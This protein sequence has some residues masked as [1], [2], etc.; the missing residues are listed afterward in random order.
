VLDEDFF[1]YKEDVDLAWRLQRLGWTAWYV[2][3][4]RAWHGRTSGGPR[5]VTML[6]IARANRRVPGWIGAISWRNQRLTQLKNDRFADYVR[7]LPW[8]ARREL[9]AWAFIVAADPQRI[10]AVPELV[11][12]L[13]RTLRKR[14][15][16][17]GRFAARARTANGLSFDRSAPTRSPAGRPVTVRSADDAETDGAPSSRGARAVEDVR[18]SAS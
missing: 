9:L 12:L 16:L 17:A 7:D 13:P 3:D 15:Y 4:A 14:R 8:I 18:R 6:E 1:M 10:G 5:S 2:P 11:R